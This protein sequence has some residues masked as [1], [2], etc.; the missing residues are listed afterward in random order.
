MSSVVAFKPTYLDAP[1]AV[2]HVPPLRCR[3]RFLWLGFSVIER[4]T[5]HADG[6]REWRRIE[7]GGTV[8][9]A[10]SAS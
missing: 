4:L 2:P 8:T 10:R 6:R 9:L 7:C 5:V 3:L 1:S